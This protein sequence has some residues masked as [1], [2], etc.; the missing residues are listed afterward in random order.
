MIEAIG[1]YRGDTHVSA[2]YFRHHGFGP[3]RKRQIK[4]AGDERLAQQGTAVDVNH[5]EID[6]VF[7]EN[8]RAFAHFEDI[9]VDTGAAVTETN[10]FEILCPGDL[11][12]NQANENRQ[13]P[14]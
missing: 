14:D 12:P 6:T 8:A 10:F 11:H 1:D 7:F 13:Y 3:L 2:A 9:V 5:F 4:S